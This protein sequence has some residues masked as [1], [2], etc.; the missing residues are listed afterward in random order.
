MFRL[1][2]L[3]GAL[4]A[5]LIPALADGVLVPP[6]K[7]NWG[8]APAFLPRGAQAAI[9]SGDPAA[10]GSY[11]VRLKM[12]AGYRIPAHHHPTTEHVT[13][14]SGDF[15]LGMGDRLDVGSGQ[16]LTAG[17]YAEAPANMNH[18]AWATTETIV[19]VH[20]QGPFTITYV[21]PSDDP[22]QAK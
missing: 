2:V 13:V 20:G 5:S 19:Q 15:H 10:E 4:L 6:D 3:S 11:V 16:S 8:P 9:L 17:G 1:T 18:F 7:V 14:L 12:P 22:R 21:N